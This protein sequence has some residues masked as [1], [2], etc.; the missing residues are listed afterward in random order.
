M[1]EYTYSEI[2]YSIQGEGE[3][4]GVPTGWLRLFGC[5]LNCH[6]FGQKDPT[7][8]ES[9][10]LPF[11]DFD[12]DVKKMEDLPV[13][14]TGCDSSY[15]WSRKYRHLAHRDTI[16][17][18]CDKVQRSMTTDTNPTGTFLHPYSGIEQHMCFTGGEPLMP[19]GQKAAVEFVKEMMVRPGGVS[20]RYAKA[21]NIPE[22]ITFETNGTQPLRPEF[23]EYF[24]NPGCY[25]GE[26]FFSVS[27][28]LWTVAGEPSE[29]AIKPE[30][31]AGYQRL[32]KRGQ[33][34]FVVGP[35]ERQWDELEQV[36]KQFRTAGV[37]YPVWIM[38]VGADAEMQKETAQIVCE[39]AFHRGYNFSARVH[40]DIWGNTIGV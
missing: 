5:N 3:Y 34:K 18:I 35:E 4:T 37:K 10:K 24:D 15:S 26:L 16:E 32:S 1:K 40:V 29:K 12:Q 25:P 23:V 6:G 21:A 33:L 9:Y 36:I 31:V 20:Q 17:E 7:D 30:V 28:K 39:K 11:L 27:P 8:S 13:W 19:L 2:F 14:H 22:F 38:A